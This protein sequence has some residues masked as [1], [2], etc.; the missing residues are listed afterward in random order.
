MTVLVAV[1]IT[2]T[3]LSASFVATVSQSGLIHL[4][5]TE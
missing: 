4:M 2:D 5:K 3:V 1:L